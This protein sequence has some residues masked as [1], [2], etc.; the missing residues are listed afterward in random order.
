MLMACDVV[1]VGGLMGVLVGFILDSLRFGLVG[2]SG[3]LSAGL[4]SSF[5]L[6][7]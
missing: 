7:R 4:D 1:L 2:G 5:G 3:M 6:V